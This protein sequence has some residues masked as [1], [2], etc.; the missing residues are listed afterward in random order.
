[1]RIKY[2]G[3]KPAA[4]YVTD[5]NAL[6]FARDHLSRIFPG[7][8]VFFSGVN[9]YNVLS[10]LDL[11]LFTGV[12]ERK[13]VVPNLAW[14]IRLDK[15]TNDLVFIGDGSNTDRA[16]ETEARIDIIPYCLRATFIAEK[17]LD[18]ALERLRD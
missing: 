10:S 17:R 1:M 9:D 13:E 18:R 11:A 16:I 7:T 4:I 15:D 6:L 8:P 2:K 5:D 12:F 14:L 3:Y